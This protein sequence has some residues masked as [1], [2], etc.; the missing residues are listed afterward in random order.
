METK[1]DTA[2]N[3]KRQ[4]NGQ[5]DWNQKKNNVKKKNL[6]RLPKL[7]YVRVIDS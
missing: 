2:N 6:K 7:S 5:N 3:T 1:N 4:Q